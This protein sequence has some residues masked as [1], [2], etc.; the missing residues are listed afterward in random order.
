VNETQPE[1]KRCQI[2]DC[3]RPLKARR[4]C[5]T[6]Y[7]RNRRR[8]NPRVLLVGQEGANPRPCQECGASIPPRQRVAPLVCS[9]ACRNRRDK[10]RRRERMADLRE[11]LILGIARL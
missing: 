5:G 3:R 11:R 7:E 6:H 4:M 1:A 8:G 2:E 10:R 9:L